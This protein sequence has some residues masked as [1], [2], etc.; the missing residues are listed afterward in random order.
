MHRDKYSSGRFGYRDFPRL[1]RV[2]RMG[3]GI[4]GGLT[5]GDIDDEI[6]LRL[7][8]VRRCDF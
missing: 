4:G 1:K 2:A 8:A 6:E 7:S 5:V 3:W